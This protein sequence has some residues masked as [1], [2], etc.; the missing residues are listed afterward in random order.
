[1]GSHHAPLPVMTKAYDESVRLVQSVKKHA[2]L[3]FLDKERFQS[4]K[5]GVCTIFFNKIQEFFYCNTI[6]MKC[7]QDKV[8]SS[9]TSRIRFNT[10][11]VFLKMEEGLDGN[12]LEQVTTNHTIIW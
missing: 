3:I 4:V 8:Y 6:P 7:T 9:Y 12:T 11:H 10:P 5:V 2:V 1:M